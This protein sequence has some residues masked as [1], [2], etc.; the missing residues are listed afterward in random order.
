MCS[1]KVKFVT[2][3][4]LLYRMCQH[5]ILVGT[6]CPQVLEYSSALMLMEVAHSSKIVA[7]FY[8][9]IH[10]QIPE[11][12]KVQCKILF[13]VLHT[14]SKNYFCCCFLGYVTMYSG[15]VCHNTG[16]QN[17][18]TSLSLKP[19]ILYEA[20]FFPNPCVFLA[21]LENFYRSISKYSA[22]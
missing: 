13:L 6:C 11:D 9:T 20:F 1:V 14:N 2:M 4:I 18:R 22:I 19:Q 16:A 5:V 8:E 17:T 7:N 10:S 3:K 21:L 15:S 12:S